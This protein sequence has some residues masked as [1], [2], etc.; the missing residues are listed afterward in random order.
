MNGIFGQ[1]TADEPTD[2]SLGPEL[3]GMTASGSGVTSSLPPVTSATM[4]TPPTMQTSVGPALTTVSQMVPTTFPGGMPMPVQG[5][6]KSWK[7][8]L[9]G[10]L[11]VAA[12]AGLAWYFMKKDK[13][14]K[15]Y[16][17][18][19]KGVKK[20]CPVGTEVQTLIF[21]N[22]DFDEKEAVS[23]AKKGGFSASKVDE[24]GTSF[25]IRQH[26][27][28][29]YKKGSFRTITLSDGVKA[30]IGCPRIK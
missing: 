2:D 27:P 1:L 24:T 6:Q 26:L 12:V 29:R 23:W 4:A 7:P 16:T 17:D 21:D 3:P 30:V 10:G 11:A 15:E 28:T 20:R 8:W 9:I 14:N 25:R 5:Q 19:P 18:N 13:D 22:Q